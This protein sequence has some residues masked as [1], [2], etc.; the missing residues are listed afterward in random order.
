MIRSLVDALLQGGTPVSAAAV[1]AML[2][3]AVRQQLRSG[4]MLANV[5]SMLH[6]CCSQP[7]HSNFNGIPAIYP[8]VS[9]PHSFNYA[10]QVGV[11]CLGMNHQGAMV[12]SL[13]SGR[14][15]LSRPTNLPGMGFNT[16]TVSNEQD[17]LTTATASVAPASPPAPT[18]DTSAMQ[19]S[20]AEDDWMELH[21]HTM[22]ADRSWVGA[23]V[24]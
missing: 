9:G 20:S 14:A 6:V 7:S 17:R 16:V 4:D 11:P 1:S 23:T 12:N 21:M 10:Q 19:S 5:Q 24:C 8:Q 13:G 15:L 18:I 22:V 3:H 2:P